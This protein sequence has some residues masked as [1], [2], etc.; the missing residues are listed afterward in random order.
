MLSFHADTF[1]WWSRN[2]EIKLKIHGLLLLMCRVVSVTMS[3]P[4]VCLKL[5]SS[6]LF[7][8][9]LA[10]CPQGQCGKIRLSSSHSKTYRPDQ[11]IRIF[12][13]HRKNMILK[14]NI[15]TVTPSPGVT[16]CYCLCSAISPPTQ[17]TWG[18]GADGHTDA[19]LFKTYDLLLYKV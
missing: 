5:T 16:R 6:F 8:F 12:E 7:I 10:E 4:D 9:A 11:S 3:H 1:H 15:F 19:T 13:Y 18:P 14:L 2:H 17:T